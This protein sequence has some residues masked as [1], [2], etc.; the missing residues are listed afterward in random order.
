[1]PGAA[2]VACRFVISRHTMNGWPDM[3]FPELKYGFEFNRVELP[4]GQNIAYT[5]EGAGVHTLLFIHG[6]ASYL[7][8]WRKNIQMLRRNFRCIAIDLPG[9]GKST[10]GVF[11]GSMS[12]YSQTIHQFIE[13]LGLVRVVLVGHSMGGQIA[14]SLTLEKPD[15]VESLILLAPAGF[16]VF[17]K[18]E[19]TLIKRIF[20]A[21]TFA[22]SD[23]AQIRASYGS[24]FF[25][26]P[27]DIEPMIQDRLNMRNWKNFESHSQ[28]V[29]NSLYA[30]L[31]EPVFDRLHEISQKTLIMYGRNDKLIPH[32]VLHMNTATEQ[33]AKAGAEQIK[34][35][36]LKFL[37][38]CGHFIQFEKAC[39]VNKAISSFLIP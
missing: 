34:N 12:F 21:Q 39:E 19:I 9:Y 4:N 22:A 38:G 1:M 36:G 29:A 26:M 20:T 16:E 24:N 37:D 13:R 30:L 7:P 25:I 35:S 14:L 17:A 23:E 32:P 5:D 31:D 18:D 15:A 6:L 3:Q 2:P 10:A 33:I 8:A 28:V 27:L 11:S